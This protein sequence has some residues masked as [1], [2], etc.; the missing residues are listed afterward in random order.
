MDRSDP[1][2]R[3]R[4]GIVAGGGTLPALLIEACRGTGRSCFVLAI[5]GQAE[6]AVIGD[7]PQAWVRLGAVGEAF[8]I[9]RAQGIGE[10]VLAGPVQRPS[11]ADLRP[12]LRG[13]AMLARIGPKMFGDDGLLTAVIRE[14]EAEGF[15]VVGA[16]DVL[17]ELLPPAGPLGRRA[18]D[19]RA[20]A[21]IARG[22]AVLTALGPLDVG[23]AVVVQQG[24]VLAV[25]AVEGTDRLL[26]RAG[27]LRREGPGGVL[28][29]I[30]KRGQE[31]RVDLPSIGVRTV[32]AAVG[33]G[34]AGIAVEAH[35]SLVL[36]RAGVVAAADAAGLFVYGVAVTR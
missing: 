12:D 20:A 27:A 15:R 6:R 24:L 22:V 2:L 9:L 29:K 18:P 23:Q 14:I 32:A 28:V 36:D 4:L 8:A 16:D 10:L 19:P 31:R 17:A 7:A 5:E 21:D 35:G 1:Q 33:A 13:A 25:E 34:L 26:D 30:A 11:L 3:P